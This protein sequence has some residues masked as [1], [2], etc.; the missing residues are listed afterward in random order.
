MNPNG[1]VI[2]NEHIN[3]STADLTID[4]GYSFGPV[5]RTAAWAFMAF[6]VLA[7][8]FGGGGIFFGILVTLAGLFALTS[9][10]G[11]QLC[12]SNNC[13]R[14]YG[15]FFGIKTGKWF[16]THGLPDIT[17]MKLGR[18]RE[19]A[20]MIPV[21]GNVSPGFEMDATV[22]EVYL[23]SSNHR[24]RV[25]IKVCKSSKE[26][27]AFAKD[28][29]EKMGKKLVEFNPQISEASKAIKNRR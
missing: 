8:Y 24:K 9:K 17:V 22:N 19:V 23:L 11:T 25:L 5:T 16:P 7:M 12:F 26:G 18:K 2:N 21:V 10:H 28:L 4:N 6:G 1:K 15:A 13:M 14:E 27:F 20:I 3:S 29:A